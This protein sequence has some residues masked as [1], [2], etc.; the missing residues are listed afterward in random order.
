MG[1]LR[2]VSDL[3][4]TAGVFELAG[5]LGQTGYLKRVDSRIALTCEFLGRP[6]AGS[7]YASVSELAVNDI[8][9]LL[10]HRRPPGRR[11]A[12]PCRT[13][14]DSMTGAGLLDVDVLAVRQRSQVTS[15]T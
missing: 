7:A 6:V 2:A 5:Q 10:S 9:E 13:R 15:A 12:P 8:I 14:G 3:P 11:P 1:R 4:S